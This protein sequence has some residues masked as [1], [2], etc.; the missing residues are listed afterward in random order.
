M[1]L[2]EIARIIGVTKERVKQIEQDC[3]ED[4]LLGA[5]SPNTQE[6]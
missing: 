5:P 4:A 1:T 3:P 2:E 6:C